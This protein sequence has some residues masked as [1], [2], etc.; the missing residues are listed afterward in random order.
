MASAL[1]KTACSLGALLMVAGVWVTSA[2]GAPQPKQGGGNV[3]RRLADDPLPPNFVR[4]GEVLVRLAGG[5]NAE[6][7]AAQRGWEIR[8]E[9]RFAPNTYVFSGVQGELAVAVQTLRQTPGV[10]LASDNPVRRPHALP[11]INSTDPLRARQWALGVIGSPGFWGIAVGERLVNGPKQ[12][13]VVVGLIDSGVEVSHPDLADNWLYNG[14]NGEAGFDLVLDIPYDESNA[15]F[16]LINHGTSMAGCIAPTTNNAIGIAG[17]PWEA[18]K[19][20]PCRIDDVIVVNNTLVSVLSTDALIDAIYYCIQEQVDVINMS[21]GGF[22]PNPLEQQAVTDAYN[23]GIVIC[24]SSG[25]DRFFGVSPPVNFPAAYPETIAVGAV[26]PS[27]EL[28]FYSNGGPELDVVAPGGNDATFGDTTRLVISTDSFSFGQSLPFGY[29]A[30]QGTSQAAAYCSG[31]VATLISQGAL[32]TTLS[33]PEQVEAIRTLL[34]TTARN[35]QGGFNNDFGFGI[36]NAENALKSFS[37]YV[38]VTAP[39]PGE[40]TASFS[41]P[42]D[43][44]IIFPPGIGTGIGPGDFELQ[45][46][47]TDRTDDVEIVDPDGGQI[48]YEPD[49]ETRYGIGINRLNIIAEHPIVPDCQ[50]S[51]EGPAVGRIPE[52]SYRF[53]MQPRT[54]VAGLKMFSLPFELQ[55]GDVVPTNTLNFIAG[56][57]IVRLARWLPEQFRYAI[58]DAS[59]SPQDPEA[60]LTTED[61]GVAR[62]P[63]GVGYFARVVNGTQLQILGRS[64][65]VG[66]YRIPLKPGFN[67]IGN[68]YSFRVPWSVVN[69][70]FGN[71]ILS[72]Q[73]AASRNLMRNTIWRYQDGRY[74]FQA[75]PNGELVPWEAHWVRS[76]RDL[77]L[78]VPRVGSFNPFS[79]SAAPPA[80]AAG[81][82]ERSMRLLADGS[83]AGEVFLGQNRVARDGN[84]ALDVENPPAFAASAEVRVRHRDWGAFSGAYARDVRSHRAAA[85][86]WDLEVETSRAGAE[87]KLAWDAFPRNTKALLHLNGMPVARTLNRQGELVLPTRQPGLQKLTVTVVPLR[88]GRG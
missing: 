57:N 23:Q 82:W 7:F 17:L 39:T 83:L 10:L 28:A 68:P 38:D 45:I 8:K 78:I 59:T 3:G 60:S 41:E 55:E 13:P 81:G 42:V 77:E 84:D 30:E 67:M 21:L 27:G 24:A 65:R 64:E 44:R 31:V 46:N 79:A 12:D 34:H 52:R 69:V 71:E 70:R 72:I 80:P 32:D 40:V 25:N 35:P 18:V 11:A 50:R 14:P 63:I 48:V 51:L 33:P 6:A 22:F 16:Q 86:R 19:I 47:G 74:T 58:F 53:R 37:Q 15:F 2:S 49:N 29:A 76:F 73:E 62:P 36:I 61:A 26:G 85:Q 54:E 66:F 4:P 43:A 75:L 1:S 88:G 87:V 9:L 56:G 20:L 5:V